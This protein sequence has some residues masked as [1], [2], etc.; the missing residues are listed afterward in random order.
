[1]TVSE[2]DSMAIINGSYEGSRVRLSIDT[3]SLL[4][5]LMPFDET[6]ATCID[7]YMKLLRCI[8]VS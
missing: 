2:G 6:Q 8:D 7:A 1:M 5:I 3:R 4:G